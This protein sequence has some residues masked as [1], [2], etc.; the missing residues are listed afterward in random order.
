M[1]QL[2]IAK[3]IEFITV[4]KPKE[5]REVLQISGVNVGGEI[6][7]QKLEEIVQEETIKGNEVIADNIA[8]LVNQ[9]FD[10]SPLFSKQE[11]SGFSGKRQITILGSNNTKKIVEY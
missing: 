5:L 4:N 10:L 8:I 7:M 11:W 6:T 3:M 2:N 1:K 9:T